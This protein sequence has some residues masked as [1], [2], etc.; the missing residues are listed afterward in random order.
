MLTLKQDFPDI[1]DEIERA[2]T[3]DEVLA[4]ALLD[5]RHACKCMANRDSQAANRAQWIEIHAELVME[6]RQRLQALRNK[7]DN[8]DNQKE[9]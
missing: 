1:A 2:A 4:E 5:Y 6:I 8:F 3:F 9:E 7:T